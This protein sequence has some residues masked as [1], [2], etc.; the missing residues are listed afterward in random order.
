[1][2]PKRADSE[3]IRGPPLVVVPNGPLGEPLWSDDVL[4]G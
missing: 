1:M 2:K 3:L 4:M